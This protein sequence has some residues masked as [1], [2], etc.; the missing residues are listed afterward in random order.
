MV[1]SR[2]GENEGPAR[3]PAVG[4]H[5]ATRATAGLATG[6]V[7]VVEKRC[8]IHPVVACRAFR[9]GP[10]RI[11]AS[12]AEAPG[13]HG[14]W[15]R[16]RHVFLHNATR[17]VP[18]YRVSFAVASHC[19]TFRLESGS[20]LE[21]PGSYRSMWKDR[22]DEKTSRMSLRLRKKQATS[23]VGRTALMGGDRTRD[24][25]PHRLM[26]EIDISILKST[27][28]VVIRAISPIGHAC[29]HRAGKARDR[30]TSRAETAEGLPPCKSPALF[31]CV[32]RNRYADSLEK[33]RVRDFLGHFSVTHREM[34]STA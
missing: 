11:A 17:V 12:F 10:V 5:T 20:S 4:R 14:R 21:L 31:F 33:R 19:I 32:C 3:R 7:A 6:S 8:V 29:D 25:V 23:P 1:S 16:V 2:P 34:N 30:Q 22:S 27:H 18:G 13:C 28:A 24:P 15:I 26:D 9:P